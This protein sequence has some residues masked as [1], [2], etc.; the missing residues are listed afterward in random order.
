VVWAGRAAPSVGCPAGRIEPK[1]A[2]IGMMDTTSIQHNDMA[3]VERVADDDSMTAWRKIS[4]LIS[5]EEFYEKI[6]T[7]RSWH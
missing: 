6:K 3:Q 7:K 5:G 4:F 2:L 1:A